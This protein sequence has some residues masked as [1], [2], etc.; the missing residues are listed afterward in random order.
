MLQKNYTGIVNPIVRDMY[1][2][3]NIYYFIDTHYELYLNTSEQLYIIPTSILIA[4]RVFYFVFIVFNQKKGLR[5]HKCRVNS[6]PGSIVSRRELATRHQYKSRTDVVA[7]RRSRRRCRLNR[8]WRTRQMWP[9][10]IT[11]P[12]QWPIASRDKLLLAHQIATPEIDFRVAPH[13]QVNQ[14]GRVRTRIGNGG[15]GIGR[16]KIKVRVCGNTGKG[17]VQFFKLGILLYMP[18][19][20]NFYYII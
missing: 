16:T 20:A 8:R 2:K 3:L 14:M 1:L 10:Q 11:R 15:I 7:A 6:R 18:I 4:N 12:E 13:G 9:K 5:N 17:A 19:Y